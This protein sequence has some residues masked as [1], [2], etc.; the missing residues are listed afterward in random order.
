MKL[1]VTVVQDQD[2]PLLLDALMQRE[3]G[4]TKLASTGGFLR[5]G[6]TTLLVGIEDDQVDAVI[7]IINEICRSRT[8]TITPLPPFNGS[9]EAY[10]SSPLEVNVGGATI[11]VLDVEQFIKL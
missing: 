3:Y 5:V 6:N 8:K 9:V 1:L 10:I 11:F 2:A 4:V 7:A